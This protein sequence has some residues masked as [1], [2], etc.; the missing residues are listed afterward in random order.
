M[1]CLS[2]SSACAAGFHVL[3]FF[4][5]GARSCRTSVCPSV[6]PDSSLQ[7]FPLNSIQISP[8]FFLSCCQVRFC[9]IRNTAPTKKGKKKKRGTG[10]NDKAKETH[11]HKYAYTHS[12]GCTSACTGSHMQSN[13]EAGIPV[14]D[15]ERFTT[16][17][18]STFS[19]L[20][21]FCF[22][23]Q[24]QQLRQLTPFSRSKS[25][26]NFIYRQIHQQRVH[27]SVHIL[28]AMSCMNQD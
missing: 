3:H 22:P 1:Q 7:S 12:H 24:E 13:T 10:M 23:H 9:C 20:F 8:T 5:S 15:H 28:T 25:E 26:A 27:T 6:R 21:Y 14:R 4:S 2:L 19:R 16:N 11:I 17:Y 18:T